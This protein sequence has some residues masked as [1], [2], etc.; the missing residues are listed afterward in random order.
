MRWYGIHI[1]YEE[2]LSIYQYL[3]KYCQ[4]NCMNLISVIWQ[5]RRT[6]KAY[7]QQNEMQN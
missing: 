1:I 5:G 3:N 6:G 7:I 4:S 2:S